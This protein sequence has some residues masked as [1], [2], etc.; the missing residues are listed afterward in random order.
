MADP[1]WLDPAVDPNDRN[2]LHEVVTVLNF[3]LTIAEFP[4]CLTQHASFVLLTGA[5]VLSRCS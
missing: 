1:R 4:D 2:K 3:F 5:V